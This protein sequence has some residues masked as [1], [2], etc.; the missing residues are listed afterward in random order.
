MVLIEQLTTDVS[1][2]QTCAYSPQQLSLLNFLINIV[3]N[4]ISALKM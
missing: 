3:S 2:K 4:I 1:A